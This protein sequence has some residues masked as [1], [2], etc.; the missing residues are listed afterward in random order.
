MS[1][2]DKDDKTTVPKRGLSFKGRDAILSSVGLLLALVAD[3]L[4]FAAIIFIMAA[5]FSGY[6]SMIYFTPLLFSGLI[7]ALMI[8]AIIGKPE[9]L[10]KHFLFVCT[11][12]GVLIVLV[13]ISF[14][15]FPWYLEDAIPAR[16]KFPLFGQA[17]LHGW[18]ALT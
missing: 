1:K 18:F 6:W 7:L 14:V 16:E 11:D 8:M 15:S 2:G 10:L 13:A 4:M 3:A 17:L 5:R 12:L 9:V